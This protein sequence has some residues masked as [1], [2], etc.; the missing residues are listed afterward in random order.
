MSKSNPRLSN[1]SAKYIEFKGDIGKFFY[2]DK[3]KEDRVELSMPFYFVVLDELCSIK[4]YSKR[5]KSGIYSNEVRSI[6]DD[7]LRVKSFQGG[8]NIIGKYSD[9]KDQALR[10]GGKFCKSVYA[11]LITGKDEYELVNFQFHGASFSGT[12]EKCVSGWMNKKFNIE[13]F[14]VVVKETESGING[15]VDFLAPIFGKFNLTPEVD[16]AAIEMDKKLQVYLNSY[17]NQQIE[18]EATV[19]SGTIDPIYSEEYIDE[20]MAEVKEKAKNQLKEGDAD[21]LPF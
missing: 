13:Q 7:I 16:R 10:D 19:D 15:N 20:K 2:Y 5:A 3:E 18:K 14:G 8:I 6:K 12:G 21:D 1:P 17:L 4:G 11:M 9:I